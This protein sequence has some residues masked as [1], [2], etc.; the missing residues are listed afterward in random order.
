M[1]CAASLRDLC[2]QLRI[3]A[4]VKATSELTHLD[5]DEQLVSLTGNLVRMWKETSDTVVMSHLDKTAA[6]RKAK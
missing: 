4:S 6:T 5:R 3:L 2:Q 1:L